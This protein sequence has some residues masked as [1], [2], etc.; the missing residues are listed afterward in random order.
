[1]GVVEWLQP[2]ASLVQGQSDQIF[3][4]EFVKV[5]K[6]YISTETAPRGKVSHHIAPVLD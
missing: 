4:E 3:I 2:F 6:G 5:Q 1:M